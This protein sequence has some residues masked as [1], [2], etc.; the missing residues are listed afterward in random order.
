MTQDTDAPKN[1]P[2]APPSASTPARLTAP[3]EGWREGKTGDLADLCKAFGL[4]VTGNR[5]GLLK[6]LERHFHGSSLEH[7]NGRVVCPH[8]QRPAHCNGTRWLSDTVLR[9]FYKCT[10]RRRHSFTLDQHVKPQGDAK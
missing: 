7:V 8:C 6:R 1:L 3:P 9:R 5:A 2:A 4:P 10:G